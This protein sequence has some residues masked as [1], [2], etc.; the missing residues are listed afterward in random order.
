MIHLAISCQPQE[1]NSTKSSSSDS[2]GTS[3][4]YQEEYSFIP[5]SPSVDRVQFELKDK[6]F[7][8]LDTLLLSKAIG[9]V[10]QK[11]SCGIGVDIKLYNE[12]SNGDTVLSEYWYIGDDNAYPVQPIPNDI[13]LLLEFSDFYLADSDA[14]NQNYL[15]KV[16]IQLLFGQTFNCYQ[17]INPKFSSAYLVF[18]NQ[19]SGENMFNKRFFLLNN[20]NI[21]EFINDWQTKNSEQ[22]CDY[23]LNQIIINLELR[24]TNWK[25][26]FELVH[27]F[28]VCGEVPRR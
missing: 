3:E 11:H 28:P 13:N 19:L 23:N 6:T 10:Y 17:P 4:E 15:I 2:V 20:I 14:S 1:S 9:N 12:T 21:K 7:I 8:K 27:C 26:P 18:N 22:D 5:F 25:H 24:E 16:Y